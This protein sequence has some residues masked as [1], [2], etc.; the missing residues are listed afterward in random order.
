MA[1]PGAWTLSN[2]AKNQNGE[3]LIEALNDSTLSIKLNKAFPPFLGILSMQYCS[4]VPKEAVEHYGSEFGR[5]P[6]GT[7]PFY[8]KNWEESVKLVLRRNPN[9]FEFENG[10]Q[11]PY[12]DS[13]SV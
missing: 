2:V 10:E 4:V 7:G 9:Y 11:L 6:I 3:Y 5:N 12:M 8:L 1:S 13:V